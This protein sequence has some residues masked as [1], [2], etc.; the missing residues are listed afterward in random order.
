[1]VASKAWIGLPQEPQPEDVYD[2]HIRLTRLMLG[3]MNRYFVYKKDGAEKPQGRTGDV[4]QRPSRE[5][6]R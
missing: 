2:I 1:D 5:R 4:Q 3:F 6:R